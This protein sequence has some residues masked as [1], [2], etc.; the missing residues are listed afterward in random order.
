MSRGVADLFFLFK[1]SFASFLAFAVS[2]AG[3]GR[4]VAPNGYK[5]G[6]RNAISG[7]EGAV[8]GSDGRGG[9]AAGEGCKTVEGATSPKKPCGAS[10]TTKRPS[11]F[12]AQN[13]RVA[14]STVLQPS[15]AA[16]PPRPRNRVRPSQVATALGGSIRCHP[17]KAC[18]EALPTYFS[19]LSYLSHLSW[20]LQFHM[21]VPE[22]GW[23]LT[24]TRLAEEM[25]SAA[26]RARCTVQTAGPRSMVS[27]LGHGR[28]IGWAFHDRFVQDRLESRCG[29][30]D[31]NGGLG[32]CSMFPATLQRGGMGRLP[33]T[34]TLYR[35]GGDRAG[36]QD[37]A[38]RV[39]YAVRII[40]SRIVP[41][42]SGVISVA[43]AIAKPT[44]KGERRSAVGLGLGQRG[45]QGQCGE[46]QNGQNEEFAM[47]G[48]LNPSR[49]TKLDNRAFR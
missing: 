12:S 5:I 24:D 41:R 43:V 33:A 28:V 31:A 8:Y 10:P 37:H 1:L 9:F 15:P 47:H 44:K 42:R 19:Y 6:G 39:V 20:P 25:R 4:W 35:I 26:A 16:N 38:I 30:G 46:R 13:S 48:G 49:S 45:N 17:S 11:V 36:R 22:G 2:H 7:G 34:E 40:I 27:E 14:P 3:T 18:R 21:R 32:L 23:H 29:M